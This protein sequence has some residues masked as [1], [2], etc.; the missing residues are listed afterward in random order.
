MRSRA[1]KQRLCFCCLLGIGLALEPG[2]DALSFSVLHSFGPS[3]WS[4][5]TDL[6][7]SGATLYGAAN[8]GTN[9][10]S[11][12]V[13]AVDI[14]DSNYSVLYTFSATGGFITY[15]NGDG[16]FPN[17]LILL[18]N[19]LYGTTEAGGPTGHGTIFTVQT[20]GVGCTNLHFFDYRSNGI[21]PLSS[22]VLWAST[23]YGITGG[24]GTAGNGTVF[25]INADGSGF[26]NLYD[27]QNT[28]DGEVPNSLM[29]WENVLY[30]TAEVGG[31]N[32]AGGIFTVNTN[33]TGFRDLHSFA[34]LSGATNADG[35]SPL[36]PLVASADTIFGTTASGGTEGGGT[37]FSIHTDGTKF[38]NLYNFRGGNDGFTPQA[39]LCIAGNIL[40][41]TTYYGGTNDSGTVYAIKTDGTGY[42]SLYSFTG[43]SDGAYPR[44]ELTV[45]GNR[46]YGTASEGGANGAGTIFS[47]TLPLPP[48]LN[49]ARAETNITLTWPTNGISFTLQSATNLVPPVAWTAVSTLPIVISGQN[50]VTN[51]L[52]GTQQFYRL[53]Q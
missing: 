26:T 2:V 32:G 38:S 10:G 23:F 7:L 30:G 37:I 13:F 39:G 19:D 33:G 44:A 9:N 20:N 35:Y 49:I 51:P 11:G 50:T 52:S 42:V 47:L 21:A 8:G 1:K 43:G 24:G 6:I 14:T 17:G 4:P 16:A 31:T 18:G 12:V 46:L 27:L 22:L 29:I 53:S 28:E 25:S 48:D 41:G 45:S 5:D 15:T 34:A 36:G 3:D 40:F